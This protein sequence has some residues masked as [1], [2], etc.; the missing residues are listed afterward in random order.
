M[1]RNFL[2]LLLG[3]MTIAT[4][5]QN[6]YFPPMT[7]S[8]WDTISPASLGWCEDKIDTLYGF[9][10]QRETKAFIVLK[11]GK[12]AL[13]KYFGT[14]TQDSLWHWASASKSFTAFLAG[15]AQQEG[16]FSIDD[17][18]SDYLDTGWTACAPEKE[19]KITIRHQLTMTTGLDQGVP[20][21]GCTIDTCLQYLTDAGTNWAYHNAPYYLIQKIIDTT[22]GNFNAYAN[23]KIRSQ[24]GMNGGF[25]S[26][27]DGKINYSNARSMAR[28]G[29]LVLNKGNWN[30]NQIMTDSVYFNQ[31]VNAS[32]SLNPFYGYLW[33]LNDMNPAIAPPVPLT[34]PFFP[35]APTDAIVA[36]G[37]NGQLINIAPSQNLVFIRMGELPTDLSNTPGSFNDSIWIKLN[38][39]MCNTISINYTSFDTFKM[40]VYPNPANSIIS[41]KTNQKIESIRI[42]NMT[43]NLVAIDQTPDQT[44]FTLPDT[45]TS[46][47]YLLKIDT[48]SGIITRKIIIGK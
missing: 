28:F 35:N 18:T 12:I 26:F 42:Y 25:F 29:L 36:L 5:A 47:I 8:D 39:I 14:F 48:E 6:T 37:K 10:N 13:E 1:K 23:A 34:Q 44:Q 27:G 33:W 21:E 41:I 22:T 43:G 16:Y 19:E 30:S 40:T 4:K 46:G 2:I 11:D 7:G 15:I 17:T 20:V 9:L 24:I 38:D 31:M 45:L 3:L 32:T